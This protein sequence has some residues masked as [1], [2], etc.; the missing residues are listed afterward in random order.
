[1][2]F[3][4]RSQAGGDA[5]DD[6]RVA[7][8]P[9]RS[10]A[11]AQKLALLA[12]V[13]S[14][15]LT[16][17]DVSKIGIA[18]P[19]I[20]ESL[21]SGNVSVQLMIVGYTVAYAVFL[22]PFGRLGDIVSRKGVFIAGLGLFTLCSLLCAIAPST[23]L[24]V[25][26][27]IAQGASAGVLMPQVI[28]L[29]QLLYAPETRTRPLSILAVVIAL[30]SAVGPVFAGIVLGV[31]DG[32]DGWRW[33]F[34]V[35]VAV[36]LVIVPL[37]IWLLPNPG[38]ERRRGFDGVGA[39]LL[40]LGICLT[41][42]PLGSLSVEEPF[43]AS[44][45]L[46][47]VTSFVFGVL[48]LV[49]FVR[50]E[51]ARARGG[52]EALLDPK[53]FLLRS[54]P[55]GLVIGAMSY[56]SGT[57]SSIVLTLYLQEQL[58]LSAMM[59]GLI[60]VPSAV[61]VSLVASRVGTQPSTV[62]FSR[63][64]LGIRFKIVSLIAIAAGLI[65]LPEPA[66]AAVIGILL[67]SYGAGKGMVA[68]PNQARTLLQVPE[69]RSSAAASTIQLFQRVGSAIG[70]ALSLTLYYGVPEIA[71]LPGVTIGGAELAM[72]LCAAMLTIALA[73]AIRDDRRTLPH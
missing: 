59:T 42:F 17:L 51:R 33:L 62:A 39:T 16:I 28:G 48:V 69:Y 61:V 57:G 50:Y 71:L 40:S 70:I 38:S 4:R 34:W 7:G 15:G 64:G 8:D 21:G 53:L 10:G 25:A 37:A 55:T 68:A 47:S 26:G 65:W 24:L 18:V 9:G 73:V 32:A 20:Q 31:F 60:L 11:P 27:R 63:I 5:R 46:L 30:T 66:L 56:G 67:L 13:A 19:A 6:V 43:E 14:A 36:G 29:I 2:L 49:A 3:N 23:E 41:V 72:L 35:N 12:L 44:A 58:G 1:M 22:V 52:R 45:V 54:F